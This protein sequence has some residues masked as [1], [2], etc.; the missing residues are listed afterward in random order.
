MRGKSVVLT[1]IVLAVFAAGAWAQMFTEVAMI[2]PAIT[3]DVTDAAWSNYDND[4]DNDLAIVVGGRVRLFRNNS[5][6]FSDVSE[7]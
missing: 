3:G 4:G 5:W 2:S 1:A 7:S 6:V